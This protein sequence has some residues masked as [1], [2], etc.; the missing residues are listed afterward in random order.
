MNDIL[1]INFIYLISIFRPFYRFFLRSFLP[2]FILPVSIALEQ[3]GHRH[4]F[5][6]LAEE[7]VS[8]SFSALMPI[9]RLFDMSY[10]YSCSSDTPLYTRMEGSREGKKA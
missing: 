2:S 4:I 1:I 7:A 10:I 8:N 5:G 9:K 6:R 3:K